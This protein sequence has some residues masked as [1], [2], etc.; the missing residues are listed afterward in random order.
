MK[1]KRTISNRLCSCLLV[2][3]MVLT[4]LPVSVLAYD[5]SAE[6]WIIPAYYKLDES[7][8]F[9]L[10]QY[11]DP[12][13][14]LTHPSL[15]GNQCI[16]VTDGILDL[17]VTSKGMKDGDTIPYFRDELGVKW[18]LSK[19]AV[20]NHDNALGVSPL[21]GDEAEK[22]LLEIT[23]ARDRND[24]K[25]HTSDI[26]IS[27]GDLYGGQSPDTWPCYI[28]WYG[29]KMA[30]GEEIPDTYQVSYNLNLPTGTTTVYPVVKYATGTKMSIDENDGDLS[31][32][33]NSVAG[34]T[35][36]VVAGEYTIPKLL[37]DNGEGEYIDFLAFDIKADNSKYNIYYDF[38]GWEI[39]GTTYNTGDV[40]DDISEF[41]ES[42]GT[43]EFKA[44]W[45]PVTPLTNEQLVE[46]KQEQQLSLEL[47]LPYAVN[48][49]NQTNMLLQ[50]TDSEN[51]TSGP[52]TLDETET[53]HYQITVPISQSFTGSDDGTLYNE[54]F[55]KLTVHL[56]VD[57]KLEFANVSDGKATLTVDPGPMNLIGTNIED[58]KITGNTITF[59]ASQVPD[60]IQ[61]TFQWFDGSARDRDL[62]APIKI[63]GLE[64][65]LKD[66]LEI[67]P[68][69][70]QIQTSANITGTINVQQKTMQNRFYY[71]AAY[72]LLTDP[73]GDTRPWLDYFGN[74]T[75]Y[76]TGLVHAL[77]FMD[78][79][80]K[81]IDL[82][83][84]E[85]LNLTANP[86]T[87][88]YT[89]YT[90]TATADK[91]GSISPAGAS[92]YRGDDQ[93]FTIDP[94]EGYEVD[95]VLVDDESVGAVS[96]YTFENVTGNHTISATFKP[97]VVTHT[98]TA[99]A[100]SNGSITPSGAVTVT[101]G[102][103]QTFTITP[104]KGYQIAN[105]LVDGKSVGAVSSYTFKDVTADHTIYA[106]FVKESTGG[107]T[108][109]DDYTLHYVT[110]GG[111]YLS[112]ETK[113]NKWVKEYEDLPTPV[114]DGFTFGGWYWDLRLTEP[115]TGD[116]SVDKTTVTL[117]A[118]WKNNQDYDPD[119]TGVSNWLETGQHNAYLSGYPDSTFG[120]DRNMTRA[121]V[122]QMFYALL[123][124]KDVTITASFSDVPADAWYAKAVNTLASLG[125]LG[126]YP[127]GTF[128][129]DAPITRAE[130]A[131]IALAFAYDPVNASCSYTD[132]NTAA[133]YYIYVAQATTYGWIGGY[134]DGTFRPNNSIT[135]AEVCVIVN[136]MLGR[137]ADQDYIDRSSAALADFVDL[138]GSHWAYYTIME[139]TNTHDYTSTS[140]GEAWDNVK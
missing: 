59:D 71:R 57:D 40:I 139:A 55:M 135:R 27:A 84:N 26:T 5:S 54:E 49:I 93:T 106:T 123:L 45:E 21:E 78:Y 17:W 81:D 80:L 119:H 65:K 131:A 118:K 137:E 102:A 96:T 30:E 112:D 56:N 91:N 38:K 28:V 90:I 46:A 22:V 115:V 86:V 85:M 127:D 10:G 105:V 2:L 31:G 79:V 134:P 16:Q 36:E 114:R 70:F 129:P 3:A 133:W 13:S 8:N 60:D 132:V 73:V 32:V 33:T 18:E 111:N 109:R 44:K 125:M 35:D 62:S 74:G 58:E 47:F 77:Q 68:E 34:L 67:D 76:T 69:A 39:N 19:I 120:P 110:N 12:G 99:T 4:F 122:A 41:A 23:S 42:D 66:N 121:E 37:T 25:I 11:L 29:W 14:K 83:S 24:Y 116:V 124:D 1:S 117:Y 140:A 94:E 108:V 104:N 88:T 7:G 130:F 95:D 89:Q 107:T 138:S 82:K 51:Q 103:N 72:N 97:K 6:D 113:N 20:S 126:G 98:I 9:N 100:G 101:D 52:C 43:V 15:N 64:F 61:I 92:V 87:A 53:I 75:D 50:W 136:N 63:S 48:N 128:R